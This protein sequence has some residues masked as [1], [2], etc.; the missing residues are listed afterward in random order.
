VQPAPQDQYSAVWIGIGGEF[1]ST[2]IQC[3][4][5]Q[6]SVG[7]QTTYQAWYELLP[8]NSVR[9]RQISVS[10][11]DQMQA[12]IQ[13]AD[14]MSDSWLLNITDVTK[15][16]SFQKTFIY[17]SSQLSAEWILERPNV[18]NVL[19]SLAN[20]DKVTFTNCTAT[21]GTQ[22]GAITSFP[23]L[24]S[25]MYSQISTPESAQQ[26]VDVSTVSENGTEFSVIYRRTS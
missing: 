26:L 6:D 1:D 23:A 13:L 16:V 4:T 3:G 21:I 7:G 24:Q 17:A 9:V 15:G 25:V 5:R 11:G 14:A 10:P 12:T 22:E 18:N 2:L 20:F 19:S 8:T